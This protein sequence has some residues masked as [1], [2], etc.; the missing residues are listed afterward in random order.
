MTLV[1]IYEEIVPRVEF[2]VREWPTSSHWGRC[3]SGLFK[4]VIL[5]GSETLARLCVGSYGWKVVVLTK[6]SW[7]KQLVSG[8]LEEIENIPPALALAQEV[9]RGGKS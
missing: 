5:H 2:L 1:R 9:L 6:E 3:A 4:E 8:T 7:W